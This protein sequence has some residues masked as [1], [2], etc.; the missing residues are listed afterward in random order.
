VRSFW[1]LTKKVLNDFCNIVTSAEYGDSMFLRKTLIPTYAA[2]QP[3]RPTLQSRR[4]RQYLS[5]KR[6]YLPTNPDGVATQKTN[7]S[8][9]KME[10]VCFSEELVSAYKP[11]WRH[12][13]MELRPLTGPLSIPH[14]IH[15]WIWGKG[16]MIL[17]GKNRRSRRK[18]YPGVTFSTTNPTWTALGTNPAQRDEKPTTNRLTMA[19]PGVILTK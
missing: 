1:N 14:M 13:S 16:G 19:R 6:W 15:E 7:N 11:T 5:P 18:T 4:W 8:T 12:V 9:V 10:T 2:L 17:T 3:R